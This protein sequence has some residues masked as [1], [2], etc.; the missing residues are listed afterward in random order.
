MDIAE[1]KQYLNC[2]NNFLESIVRKFIEESRAITAAINEGL[3][4]GNWE[5]IRLNAH[6]MLSSVKIFEIKELIAVLDR[7][8][9]EAGIED[10][11]EELKSEIDKLNILVEKSI[12][13]LETAFAELKQ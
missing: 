7:L 2:D 11:R 12:K 1:L 4:N 3:A 6:K 8:E 10:K 13:E 9:K 5:T